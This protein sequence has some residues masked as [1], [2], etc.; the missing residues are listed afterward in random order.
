MAE[1]CGNSGIVNLFNHRENVNEKYEAYVK[2]LKCD[3][4]KLARLYY[5]RRCV[6]NHWKGSNILDY[7]Y[8]YTV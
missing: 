2:V 1:R 4:D 8:M 3:A 6:P 5:F 7:G